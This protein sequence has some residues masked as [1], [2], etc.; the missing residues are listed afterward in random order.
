MSTCAP[1]SFW[2]TLNCLA[3]GLLASLLQRGPAAVGV[4]II[5]SGFGLTFSLAKKGNPEGGWKIWYSR[6]VLRLFPM[7][8]AAHLVY[9]ISPFMYRSDPVDYRFI[10][11]FLGDRVFP[12]DKVFYYLVPA[13]WFFGLLIQLY[14]VFP[15]LF[16]ML[17][18]FHPAKFLLISG[19]ATIACRY[20]LNSVLHA[21]G[22]YIQGAFFMARLFEFTAGMALAYMYRQR[23]SAVESGMF[24]GW[25]LLGGVFL[26]VLG[27]YSYQPD[28]FYV[29][30]DG[31]TA[32]GLFIILAHAVRWAGRVLPLAGTVLST[33]GIYSYGL[34]LLHQPYVIHF[35]HELR[36]FGLWT[37]AALGSIVVACI[38]AGSILLERYVNGI[39]TRVLDRRSRPPLST[40]P[41]S[42]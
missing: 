12:V 40:T 26:Y 35:G 3:E 28:F 31:L 23:P 18:K 29:F 2:E 4:F 5:L 9:L 11:S 19:L 14:L 33:V 20:I 13:W 10:L 8:W 27:L 21:N 42:S 30:S 39:V 24:S 32:T 7:Y 38:T 6:R 17:Q 34:Y 37:F 22:N 25:M 1:A 36:G 16:R 41:R 15:I